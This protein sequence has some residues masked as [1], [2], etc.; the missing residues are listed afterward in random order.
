MLFVE[1]IIV[2][3]NLTLV[4]FIEGFDFKTLNYFDSS[5]VSNFAM[6]VFATKKLE[7]YLNSIKFAKE[8]KT[9]QAL[10]FLFT[11]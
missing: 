4:Y 10:A 2:L 3:Q 11:N 5:S 7:C 6:G 1:V 8:L 9:A